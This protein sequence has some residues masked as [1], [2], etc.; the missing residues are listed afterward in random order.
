METKGARLKKIRLEKGISLEEAHKK[1]KIHLNVLKAIEEDSLVNFNPV[2]IRGFLKIYCNFLG[3]DPRDY[4]ADY[5]EARIR[6]E[7]APAVEKKPDPKFKMPELKFNF[8]KSLNLRIIK[9]ALVFIFISA[10]IVGLFNLGRGVSLK[11]ALRSRHKSLPVR[12]VK[13][14]KK[15]EAAKPQ[16]TRAEAAIKSNEY[17]GQS[18]KNVSAI[19]G[20]RLTIRAKENCWIQLKSDGRVIFQGVLLKGRSESWQAKEKIELSLGNAGAVELQ[21]NDKFFPSFGKKG[22]AIKNIVITK[23]GLNIGR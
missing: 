22:Q 20:V 18:V 17:P 1:T 8:L 4:V 7:G 13:A 6:F 12:T 5:K 19:S 23:D 14:E 2:Y 15:A 16:K 9:K 11:A 10:F 21:A 3:E